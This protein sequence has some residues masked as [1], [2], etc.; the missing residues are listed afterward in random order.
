MAATATITE[1]GTARAGSGSDLSGTASE[2]T[3]TISGVTQVWIRITGA[4]YFGTGSTAADLVPIDADTWTLVFLRD[5][6][7]GRQSDTIYVSQTGGGGTLYYS[8]HN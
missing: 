3:L 4:G 8:A 5:N 1:P 7:G 2:N 6:R